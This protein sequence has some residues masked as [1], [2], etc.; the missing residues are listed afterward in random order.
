MAEPATDAGTEGR[1]PV[2]GHQGMP[3]PHDAKHARRR[4]PTTNTNISKPTRGRHAP[5]T[6]YA[7]V[8]R[9]ISRWNHRIDRLT[10]EGCVG[11][12][13]RAKEPRAKSQGPRAK[14]VAVS[15]PYAAEAGT[16]EGDVH[17]PTIA[18]GWA[19]ATGHSPG[20]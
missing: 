12:A 10:G 6:N 15:D 5:T 18:F 2:T 3:A 8:P 14:N 11:Q 17:R 9:G 20:E 4:S 1:L 16:S 13:P 19:L 7:T